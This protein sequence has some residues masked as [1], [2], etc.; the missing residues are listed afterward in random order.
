MS[1]ITDE[2]VPVSAGELCDRLAGVRAE[3]A[4]LA[5]AS[6]ASFS[7]SEAGVVV[8]GVEQVTRG[9]EALAHE[10]AG[11]IDSGQ[12]WASSGYNSFATW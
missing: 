7:E 4:T 11:G 8:A 1:L 3:L 5:Q 10:C 6:F 2:A 9:V 12:A